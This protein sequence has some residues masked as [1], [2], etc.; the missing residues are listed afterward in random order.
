MR[1]AAPESESKARGLV[2]FADRWG[3][4]ALL[5]VCAAIAAV[6]IWRVRGFYADD[7]YI[8][9][10]Y[11][12]RLL[13]GR[14]LTWTDG[15]R[16]EGFT[17]PLWLF[18]IA[19]LRL[20]GI[21]GVEA[22][23]VLGVSYVAALGVLFWRVRAWP[24]AALLLATQPGLTFWSVGGLETTGFAFWLA[25]GA[26][27]LVRLHDRARPHSERWA[28]MVGLA[29]AAAGLTRPEGLGAGAVGIL[30]LAFVRRDRPGLVIRTVTAFAVPVV[31]YQLFRFSY[32]G[33]FVSNSV[34]AKVDGVAVGPRL[35]AAWTYVRLFGRD[36]IPAV[37]LSCAVI[38]FTNGRRALAGLLAMS[39]P[40]W[41][42]LALGGGDHMPEGRM[43]VPIVVLVA[44]LAGAGGWTLPRWAKPVAMSG[45]CVVAALQWHSA[46]NR[47]TAPDAPAVTG[48]QVGRYLQDTL[49]RG[50]LV[51]VA[52]AGST[53]YFAPS[54]RFIDTLG[55]NDRHIARRQSPPYVTNLQA[56]AGHAKGDG[57]Y[58]LDR[59]PDIIVI[60]PAEGSIG[61]DDRQWFL[62]DYEL[63]NSPE[64]RERYRPYL[65]R[66]SVRGQA[67]QHWRMKMLLKDHGTLGVILWL[68][69]GSP[70]AAA[71][72][73]WGQPLLPPWKWPRVA[74]PPSNSSTTRK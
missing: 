5:L 36:W 46:Q 8:T 58:V 9:L 22:S 68:R 55:L 62:T 44:A 51:A 67:A 25:A 13:A 64:F 32:Y 59:A 18:Q 29:L 27:G 10:R 70:N 11:V 28:V 71:L 74:T 1:E 17:H 49:P 39:I 21:P 19:A 53:A 60:G 50:A 37:V 12:D 63:L 42:G 38:A 72:A 6:A 40:L 24:F 30:W 33:D 69:Q 41:L 15:E 35:H 56:M 23:R 20:L 47:E 61:N 52:T 43:L 2:A 3:S 66:L 16:V 48:T 14:G 26:F 54:L 34:H 7:S 65:F 31:A 4:A 73:A 45:A 57:A